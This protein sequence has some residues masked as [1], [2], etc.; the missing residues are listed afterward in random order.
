MSTGDYDPYATV[1]YETLKEAMAMRPRTWG[2][3]TPFEHNA[4]TIE[5]GY[6]TGCREHEKNYLK[7]IIDAKIIEDFN[8][9]M[10]DDKTVGQ[11]KALMIAK[12]GEVKE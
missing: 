3:R 8:S 12:Y 7:S 1:K 9:E 11:F 5:K 2:C 6:C 10:Y 4:N